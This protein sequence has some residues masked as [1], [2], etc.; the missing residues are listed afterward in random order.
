MNVNSRKGTKN[1]IKIEL[2]LI[3][4]RV[5][6]TKTTNSKTK[7]KQQQ[8]NKHYSNHRIIEGNESM[9]VNSRKGIRNS[10]R[11]INSTNTNTI[12]T[13]ISNKQQQQSKQTLL[14]SPEY[15]IK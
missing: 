8:Q 12:P 6:L 3:E 10:I 1:I 7:R 11:N 9:S 4:T 15:Q 5:T 14:K 13:N 2:A